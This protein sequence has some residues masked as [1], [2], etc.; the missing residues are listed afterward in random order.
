[1]RGQG[2]LDGGVGAPAAL[3]VVCT[4]NLPLVFHD[5]FHETLIVE[6]D[7]RRNGEAV[8]VTRLSMC[9]AIENSFYNVG[10]VINSKYRK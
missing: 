6:M 9:G 3:E 1:M 8:K 2:R 10:G 5:Q 4:L 7:G